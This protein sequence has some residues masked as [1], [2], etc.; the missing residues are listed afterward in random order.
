MRFNPLAQIDAVISSMVQK[1]TNSK[2][3]ISSQRQGRFDGWRLI[4]LAGLLILAAQ[5]I[6]AAYQFV[7][8]FQVAAQMDVDRIENV[9]RDPDRPWQLEAD[10][11]NYDQ[12]AD[13][14]SARGNVLIYKKNINLMA[15]YVRFDH[16]NMQAYAEGNVVLT[17]GEDVL[18]GTSMEMD[19][20][21]QI[22]S[23]ENGYLFIKESNFHL[24]GDVIK[25]V[26]KKTYTIDEAILT[27]CDGEKP[28]WKITGKK[29]K[30]KE[31]GDGT[32]RHA[33]I[34]ARNMPILY[35]PY[36]YYPARKKRQSGF[37]FPQGGN[38]DRWG[39]YYNQPFFW[40][41]DKSTDATFY[42][43]YMNFRG[44]KPGVEYRYYLDEGSKGTWMLDGYR[45]EKID[46]GTGDSSKQWGFDDGDRIVLRK[47]RDRY[48]MRGSHRQKMP[49]NIQAKLDVD[50]VSDQDYTREFKKGY[51]GWQDSKKYFEKVFNRDLDDFNDPIRTNQ[52]NF[53]KLWSSHSLNA[54]LGRSP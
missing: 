27:S 50:I 11:I 29:V 18:T 4:S 47:N 3:G 40:A 6:I 38:S 44:L 34:W 49:W 43:N 17:N 37:L 8:P 35:T 54:Q 48:W 14:Y 33:T 12:F 10:E 2:T 32:A 41:I 42:G 31:N 23:V 9:M 20:E 51:M 52:L 5:G 28:D 53:N 45:D 22:G 24:T 1:K 26:G 46:D 25:K 16:K 7:A 15:D 36:F 39:V 30:I 19:L 13:E 21:N